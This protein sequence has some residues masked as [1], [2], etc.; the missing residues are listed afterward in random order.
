MPVETTAW[1][2]QTEPTL[3]DGWAFVR[4]PLWRARYLREL[5][6]GARVRAISQGGFRTLHALASIGRLI[7]QS[8][9]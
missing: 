6:Y 8:R 7:G 3:V 1:Y 2:H 5:Y 9:V 4:R